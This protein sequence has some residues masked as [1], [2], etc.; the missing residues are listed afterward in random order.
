MAKE[1]DEA[2]RRRRDRELEREQ[3]EEEEKEHQLNESSSKPV[4]PSTDRFEELIKRAEPMIEQLNNLYN[5]FISGAERLPPTERRKQLDQVMLSLQH[6]S[7]PTL[8]AQFRYNA[9]RY[10]YTSH[11]ERWDKILRNLEK[12]SLKRQAKI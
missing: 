11:S 6:V 4:G 12:G 1:D 2:W 7:K 3:E 10:K 5:M 8:S 9:V